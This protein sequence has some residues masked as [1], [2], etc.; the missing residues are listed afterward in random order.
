MC[1]AHTTPKTHLT[2]IHYLMLFSV[3]DDSPA[4]KAG[5]SVG[6]ILVQFDG[7]VVED[8]ND[9]QRLSHQTSLT[10]RLKCT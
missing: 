3:E 1:G 2:R 4:E 7:E 6:D 8:L 9:F 10:R 5:L